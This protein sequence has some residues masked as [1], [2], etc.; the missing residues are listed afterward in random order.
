MTAI[1][2]FM[3]KTNETLRISHLFLLLGTSSSAVTVL[4]SLA[5][6]QKQNEDK[7]FC[8]LQHQTKLESWLSWPEEN[9]PFECFYSLIQGILLTVIWEQ[10]D[11]M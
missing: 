7:T 8:H 11:W 10:R 5:T 1:W 6:A 2:R 4:V 3:L 9:H